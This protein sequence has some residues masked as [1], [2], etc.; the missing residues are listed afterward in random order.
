MSYGLK[1]YIPY[2]R[3][4]G[5]NTYIHIYESDY[6]G[7]YT[8]LQADGNPLEIMVDG[9]VKNIYAG[10]VGSG[11]V[12]NVRVNPL[13]M[14]DLFTTDPQKYKVVI[15]NNSNVLWQGHINSD[16]YY[17]ELNAGKNT[18]L[19]LRANDGMAVLSKIP[20]MY[21]PSTYYTGIVTI[22][23]VFSNIFSKLNL[24]FDH[25]W[26]L[27][28]YRVKN[29]VDNIFLYLKVNQNNYINESGKAMSC[30]EVLD[31]ILK[32]FGLKMSF[33]GDV[34]YII[35]PICLHNTSLGQLFN[36]GWGET[37]STFPG[38]VLDISLGQISWYKTG[39]S[40]DINQPINQ[41]EINYNPYTLTS[42][43]YDFS[44]KDN[45]VNEGM[46]LGP[47]GWVPNRYYINNFI[48]YNDVSIHG[49]YIYKQAIKR[50]DGTDA[51]YYLKIQNIRHT[52]DG[53]YAKI[54]FPFSTVC[55][56][57]NLRLKITADYYCNTRAY[58]N[59]YDTSIAS[60]E[61]NY[62]ET[63]IGYLIGEGPESSINWQNIKILSDYTLTGSD[64]SKSNIADKWVKSCTY[65]P[66][67]GTADLSNDGI[68]NVYI[69]GHYKTNSYT[70]TD[71]NT[72]V[73]NI[74][75]EIV[76][77]SSGNV[78]EN[79]TL[80]YTA[81]Q[82]VGN[83]IFE[84]AKIDLLHGTGLYGTSRGAYIDY[85]DGV[86]SPGIYRGLEP[87]TGDLY[88]N[89][90]YVAQSFVSQYS[91]PRFV[92]SGTLNVKDQLLDIQNYL[93]TWSNYL[94]NKY[95]YIVG[96]V[97]NDKYEYMEVKMIECASTRENIN[98]IS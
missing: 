64:I 26:A 38:G 49:I 24:T 59:I 2:T 27:M 43:T 87:S 83:Y 41:L 90:Y 42:L 12:I 13:T 15:Y 91:Q 28:D 79:H 78:I 67:G 18:L 22:A 85:Y 84:P 63:S 77:G 98:I 72:L 70:T 44:N 10:T 55:K 45:W 47:Y 97:Y 30:R 17:E 11:A 68:I 36:T 56:D 93:I 80:K 65:W 58:D 92:L 4:S 25:A 23:E 94:P 52:R 16:I 88:P 35:D 74:K 37:I 61:I 19:S 54:S 95:F 39:I 82:P 89:A 32:S 8:T 69:L 7:S 33:R 86:I 57:P 53:G 6:V 40:L 71:Q 29:Y 34:I 31:S 46:W 96:G 20:Y 73:K 76:D 51:E 9:D 14:L 75:V 1:Y 66:Y 3:I 62:I 5:N 60:C 48:E 21:D 50:E 81:L